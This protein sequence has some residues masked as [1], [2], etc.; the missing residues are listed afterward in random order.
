MFFHGLVFWITDSNV[1]TNILKYTKY[2]CHII[3]EFYFKLFMMLFY[4]YNA[5]LLNV[6]MGLFKI[7]F[8]HHGTKVYYLISFHKI[9]PTF[10]E[11][12]F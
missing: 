12:N 7:I 1:E 11:L 3:P 9:E 10:D 8:E 2:I 4:I 6:E 5:D